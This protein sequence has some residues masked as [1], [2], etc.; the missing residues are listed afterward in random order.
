MGIQS[1]KATYSEAEAHLAV[2]DSMP[3]KWRALVY[4]YGFRAVEAQYC[5]GVDL[6]TATEN[7]VMNRA[8]AQADHLARVARGDYK[9]GKTSF[10]RKVGGF[11]SKTDLGVKPPPIRF[12]I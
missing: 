2:Q 12:S 1:V 6:A 5:E 9:V 11:R 4:E 8:K 3:P 10:F 7:L